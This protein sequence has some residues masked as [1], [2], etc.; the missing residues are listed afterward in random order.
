MYPQYV[1]RCRGQR[2][3]EEI[4]LRI[5]VR[6]LQQWSNPEGTADQQQGMTIGRCFCNRIDRQ[7]ASAVLD[8]ELLSDGVRE[9][10]RHDA[11][12]EIASTANLG[13]HDAHDLCG[14]G[15]RLHRD[16]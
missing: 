13:R 2:D 11:S 8:H 12:N 3:R 15:L 7:Q 9:T 14:I 16:R 4:P 5:V 10:T 6:L 1:G